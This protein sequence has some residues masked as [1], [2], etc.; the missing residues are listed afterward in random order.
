M[1]ADGFDRLAKAL[2]GGADRR[3]QL[4]SLAG[5]AGAA[6]LGGRVAGAKDRLKPNGKKCNKDAQCL[7]GLCC[8][9]AHGQ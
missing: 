2:S 8:E 6:L 3:R 1:D 7:S 9:I 5:G 4:A